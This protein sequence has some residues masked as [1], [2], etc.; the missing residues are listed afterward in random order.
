MTK[1]TIPVEVKKYSYLNIQIRNL[2]PYFVIFLFVFSYYY[3]FTERL[4]WFWYDDVQRLELADQSTLL[5]SLK[6]VFTFTSEKFQSERPM[7][8]MYVKFCGSLFSENPHYY[9]IVKTIIFSI[10]LC[11]MFYLTIKHGGN[12]FITV[13]NLIVFST[14]PSVMIVNAWIGESATFELLLKIGSFVV[15]FMLI[16][17]E[18][19]KLSPRFIALSLLIVL[20]I[21]FADK[22]KVTAKI[23]PFIFLTYLF[24][25]KNKKP[26]LYL[27]MLISILAVFPYSIL[28]A[29]QSS[30]AHLKSFYINLFKTFLSQTWLLFVFVLIIGI[31]V[32]NKAYLRDRYLLFSFLWLIYEILFYLFYPSDEMRYLFSSLAAAT[33]FLSILFSN[34]LSELT[35]E[36]FKKIAKAGFVIVIVYIFI[37]NSYWSYNFRGSFGGYF[38]L[39]DKKMK[40]INQNFKN[41]LCLYADFTKPYY[42]RDTSNKYVNLNPNNVWQERNDGIYLAGAHVKIVNPEKYESIII[43]DGMLLRMLL[44]NSNTPPAVIFDSIIQDSLYDSF[45]RM[46]NFKIRSASLYNIS[47]REDADYPQ[48]SAIYRLQ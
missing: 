34:I 45:Q 20:L 36:S 25:T 18:G 47:L 33:V 24:L 12:K 11:L 4:P 14:F 30:G 8:E 42:S 5:D 7:L 9:R 32:K 13:L 35:K 41:S 27:V 43:L 38:I 40:F 26:S 2:W 29:A 48:Y 23:I 28:F 16:S 19:K 37:F 1:G 17:E 31:L 39:V 46:V 21:I 44:R 10:T 6:K 3:F 15:F 22:S